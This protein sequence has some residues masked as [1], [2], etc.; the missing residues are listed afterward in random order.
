[1]NTV[2]ILNLD[3][4]VWTQKGEL[5]Q[6]NFLSFLT[7]PK[8]T[9]QIPFRLKYVEYDIIKYEIESMERF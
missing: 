3:V 5:P 4:K 6:G 7:Q 2:A 1:M 9:R 8:I